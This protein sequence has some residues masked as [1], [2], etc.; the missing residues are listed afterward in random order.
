MTA[1]VISNETQH[2]G[3]FQAFFVFTMHIFR[4][5][6]LLTIKLKSFYTFYDFFHRISFSF[7][8]TAPNY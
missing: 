3:K 2:Y 6:L 1:V 7:L 4:L 5:Y 8:S